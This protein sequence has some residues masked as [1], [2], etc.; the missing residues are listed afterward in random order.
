MV[1]QTYHTASHS[2]VKSLSSCERKGERQGERQSGTPAQVRDLGRVV[3]GMGGLA[4][5]VA[6]VPRVEGHQG[7][8]SATQVT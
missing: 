8:S 5:V 7:V 4:P 1:I 2:S 6:P 3:W